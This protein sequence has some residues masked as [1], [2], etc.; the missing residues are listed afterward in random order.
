MLFSVA[1]LAL[2]IL[3]QSVYGATCNRKYTIQEGDICDS[4]S[5][6]KNVSTYQLSAINTAT[7]DSSCSNLVPGN[8]ICLGYA[9]E[10]CS[11]TYRVVA[12]DTCD[13]IAANHGLNTTILYL[14]N[15]QINDECTNIYV[16]EV[17]CVSNTVQVPPQPSGTLPGAVIPT[18]A[19]PANPTAT[20][21]ADDDDIPFC[22]EL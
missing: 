4:I 16:G 12:D 19:A 20:A 6:A 18:T 1:V 2:P 3:A 10:D 14:N 13:H 21:S 8:T 11:T 5:V 7:I 22:D 15:P 17:L 9:G